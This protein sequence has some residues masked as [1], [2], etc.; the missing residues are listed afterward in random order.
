MR[1]TISKKSIILEEIIMKIKKILAL[2]IVS[3]LILTFVAACNNQGGAAEEMH[4]QIVQAMMPSSFDPTMSNEVPQSR[5]CDI[6][7]ICRPA[8]CGI[9]N[10][11]R[12][13]IP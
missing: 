12:C 6:M 7:G 13:K 4:L 1:K 8:N 11:R 3:T 10:Q 5:P 9:P 2:L